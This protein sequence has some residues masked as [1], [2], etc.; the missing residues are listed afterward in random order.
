MFSHLELL[1]EVDALTAELLAW[2][3]QAPDWPAARQ[4][5][6]LVRRLAQRSNSMRIR[7]E[8]PLVVATLGGTGTGKSSLVNALV[9]SEVTTAGHLRPTTR[10]PVLIC[11]PRITP[12]QLEIDRDKVE[13]VQRDLPALNDLV[14]LDCPDPDSTEDA[15]PG[16]NLAMLRDLL[17]HCDV[18]LVTATQ[19]KY[20]SA[21]VVQELVSA[22]PGTRLVFVQTHADSDEDIR[23]DWRRVLAADFSTGQM[24]FVDSLAALADARAGLQ[25]RGEFG[26]LVDFLTR[27]LAGAAAKRIRRANFLDLVES[28]L[29]SCREQV[30][31]GL[32][33]IEQLEAG[34]MVQRQRLAQR[35]SG[36]MRSELL[37]SRRP[38]ENRLL[39]EVASAWGFSPFSCLLRMYQGLGG[40]LSGA[41]L[42]RA[43]NPAQM[44]LWGVWET[45]RRWHRGRQTRQADSA[46]SRAVT[47][48]W[49]EAELRTAA[50]IVEG[51]A[52]EAGLK[53][54]ETQPAVVER[55]AAQAG[56]TFV[57]QAAA[58]VQT[59]LSRLA[60]RHTGWFTRWRYELLLLAMLGVLLYRFGKNFFYDSWLAVEL[61]FANVPHEP[62]GTDFLVSAGVVLLA[63]CGLLLWAFT[64]RLRRGLATAIDALAE[65]W[66]SPRVAASLFAGFENQCRQIKHFREDLERLQTTTAGLQKRL[67]EPEPRLGHRII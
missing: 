26:R 55:E 35:L 4:S 58:D 20:D 2:A 57:R 33:A 41:A 67:A 63:W 6:A 44:A 47:F 66:N 31:A 51:Y 43:R 38:W 32:P 17:P 7:L 1:A 30:D 29:A 64:L 23:E 54:D 46:A 40:L 10:K 27:E 9:G 59:L 48:S 65:Q 52:T 49:E 24:F 25:P 5:Q 19:Q 28:T 60:R 36:Q 15:S 21:R 18:L 50:M 11:H 14:L 3:D 16:S 8:A 45:G 13:L 56:A 22:A 37:T 34:L 62:L 12:A 39:G 61:G 42:W 53:R